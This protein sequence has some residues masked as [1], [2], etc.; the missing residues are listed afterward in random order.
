MHPNYLPVWMECKFWSGRMVK[1]FQCLNQ[2]P[3][4]CFNAG[5]NSLL[6]CV[7]KTGFWFNWQA[8]IQL[9]LLA[10]EIRDK[11]HHSNERELLVLSFV[12]FFLVFRHSFNYWFMFC[13]QFKSWNGQLMLRIL[14]FPI[15][16]TH[17]HTV[18]FMRMFQH[19]LFPME[20][21]SLHL[22]YK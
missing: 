12:F 8:L 19:E 14:A 7:A 6:F 3:P 11:M 5:V 9:I 4:M 21:A 20:N 16:H 15:R 18:S 17:T 2:S 22:C 13:V 1:T 10:H